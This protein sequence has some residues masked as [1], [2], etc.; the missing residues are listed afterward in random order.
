MCMCICIGSEGGVTSGAG[1]PL[2]LS[3]P[4]KLL[5]SEDERELLKEALRKRGRIA[6][7]RKDGDG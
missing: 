4:N 2:L 6:P 1:L 5:F 3:Q 7:Q